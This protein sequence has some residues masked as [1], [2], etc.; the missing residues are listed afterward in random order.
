MR[1]YRLFLSHNWTNTAS[2]CPAWHQSFDG[3]GTY[4]CWLAPYI[5]YPNLSVT[6]VHLN[7]Y[8]HP[9]S[10]FCPLKYIILKFQ[11]LV[12]CGEWSIITSP[13][14]ST[15]QVS[16][17]LNHHSDTPNSYFK[18]FE[19]VYYSYILALLFFLIIFMGSSKFVIVYIYF[20]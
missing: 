7:F 3:E 19:S 17:P 5:D 13:S 12:G 4:T 20:Q 10:F 2:P 9:S 1:Y 14:S 18:F 6:I 16:N 15:T 11:P 8:R